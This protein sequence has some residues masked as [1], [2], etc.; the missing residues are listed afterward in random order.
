MCGWARVDGLKRRASARLCWTAANR[1]SRLALPDRV[2]GIPGRYSRD[3]RFAAKREREKRERY[4]REKSLIRSGWDDAMLCNITLLACDQLHS[5]FHV[6]ALLTP[7]FHSPSH[8]ILSLDH[9]IDTK[10]IHLVGPSKQ[11]F[12]DLRRRF[13]IATEDWIGPYCHVLYSLFPHAAP[14]QPAIV[15]L[16]LSRLFCMYT[17]HAARQLHRKSSYSS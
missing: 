1:V 4:R 8:E 11:T 13:F 7:S 17:P 16:S 15:K 10:A 9:C 12:N 2:S 3:G 5:K 6:P 14:G